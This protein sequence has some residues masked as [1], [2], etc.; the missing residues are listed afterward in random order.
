[1]DSLFPADTAG[2]AKALLLGDRS[3]IDYETDTALTLSGI[4]HVVSVSGL[5]ISILLAAIFLLLGRRRFLTP[6]L[7]GAVLV[8]AAAVTGFSPSVVRSCLMNGLMLLALMAE[9]EYDPLTAISFALVVM[10]GCNPLAISAV[11]LQ[12]SAASVIGI[13]L[14]A[15]PISEWIGRWGV[16][17]EKRHNS[18]IGRLRDMICATIGVS[19]AATIATAPLTA[20]HFGAVSLVGGLTNLAV[21]W[22]INIVFIGILVCVLLSALWYS[23]GVWIA[24]ILSWGIRF[25][26]AVAGLFGGFKLAAV[27]TQSPYVA[28]WLIFAYVM[29]AVFWI[30]KYKRR[31]QLCLWLS[32]TLATAIAIS[33]LEPYTEDFRMTAVDVGQGQCIL[34]QSD[35]KTYM[36]DCGGSGDEVTADEAAA[37][38]LCQGIFRIDGLILTHYDKDH[39]GG[40]AYLLS[41]ID[42]ENVYLPAGAER[43]EYAEILKSAGAENVISVDENT[44]LNWGDTNLSIFSFGAGFSSNESSL[45]ILFQ[46]ENYDILITG[47]QSKLGEKVLLQQ[48]DIPQ[49]DVLVVG[50]HGADS[51]TAEEFLAHIRPA[52]AVISVGKDNRYGH[53]AQQLLQ[54]LEE[55][56]CQIRRTDL[57]GTIIIKR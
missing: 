24:T 36:V 45:C 40:A 12:L 26:L 56:D 3:G 4:V 51:S 38:L 15:Q 39:V 6:I 41:R 54:R 35:G 57:E 44:F 31:F 11:G 33:W 53:P 32:V 5:H 20:I 48:N 9:K 29:L 23:L 49:I 13:H 43:E 21:L 1:M 46:K 47:D 50:H 18:V 52:V 42:V 22:V 28:A 16:W 7:G 10:L 27:Y 8:L 17:A 37:A 55:Y 30:S 25:V 19:T 14:S 34:L 2:F